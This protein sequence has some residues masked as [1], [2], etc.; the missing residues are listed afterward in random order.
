MLVRARTLSPNSISLTIQAIIRAG[1]TTIT[2]LITLISQTF[3]LFITQYLVIY[4]ELVNSTIKVSISSP[5]RSAK[6]ILSSSST[7][8]FSIL[9]VMEI[10]SNISQ[11]NSIPIKFHRRELYN[12]TIMVPFIMQYSISYRSTQ[13]LISTIP[14]IDL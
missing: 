6:V 10:G 5:T 14:N 11:L 2:I 7:R 13:N 9:T 12:H 8:N 4:F 1:F 3:V